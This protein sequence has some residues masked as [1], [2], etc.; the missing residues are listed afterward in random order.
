MSR[1][2][3]D[4]NAIPNAAVFALRT[5]VKYQNCPTRL[6]QCNA[7]HLTSR[8]FHAPAC[9]VDRLA[10]AVARA[11]TSLVRL[12]EAGKCT[13]DERQFDAPCFGLGQ[14]GGKILAAGREVVGAGSSIVA[15]Q[16]LGDHS[17]AALERVRP[18]RAVGEDIDKTYRID[19]QM[20]TDREGFPES[21]PGHEHWQI[22]REFHA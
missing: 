18:A 11:P 17:G 2:D 9:P 15:T 13:L 21:L 5:M 8:G 22:N 20:T 7:R 4:R 16:H 10:R 1:P 12:V 19:A 6:S 14:H 3:T